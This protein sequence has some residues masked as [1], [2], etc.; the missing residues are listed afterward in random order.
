MKT[1][2]NIVL[3]VI[4]IIAVLVIVRTARSMTFCP[5][6]QVAVAPGQCRGTGVMPPEEK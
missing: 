4:L 5:P 2:R 3:F 6:G 1:I